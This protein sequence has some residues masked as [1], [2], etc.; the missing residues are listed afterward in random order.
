MGLMDLHS[1][2]LDWVGPDLVLST[3]EGKGPVLVPL[4]SPLGQGQKEIG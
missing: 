2:G 1:Q 3:D 4:G